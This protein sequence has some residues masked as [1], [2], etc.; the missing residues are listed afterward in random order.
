MLPIPREN[1]D[2][3]IQFILF[4]VILSK[5]LLHIYTVNIMATLQEKNKALIQKY[6]EEY[7]GK[8]NENVVDELCAD[9]FVIDY[10]M[11]GLHL[12]KEAA[13]KMMVDF[14]AV[15]NSDKSLRSMPSQV[16]AT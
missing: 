6:F 14:K 8:G 7:W 1:K 13:K 11:H 10:P 9:N 2:N 16:L 3:P 15:W 12:G 4:K 5:T